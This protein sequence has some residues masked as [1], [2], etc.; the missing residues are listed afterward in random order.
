MNVDKLI[1]VNNVEPSPLSFRAPMGMD[2]RL[3]VTYVD[4]NGAAMP[5]DIA[6]QLQLTA[7][8]SGRT[9][10]YFMPAT[11]IANGRARALIPGDA[12]TDING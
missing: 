5:G 4:R 10:T 8:S 6:G 7:R 1:V 2:T 9:T 12:L 3:N 11:D